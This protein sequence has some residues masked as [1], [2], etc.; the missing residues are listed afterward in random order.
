MKYL[1]YLLITPVVLIT[2]SFFI[3]LPLYIGVVHHDWK[4]VM[5]VGLLAFIV[6]IHA[7]FYA[8]LDMIKRG[9]K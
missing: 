2:L 1:G 8:G 7:C 9:S 4:G 6:V 3:I 5:L